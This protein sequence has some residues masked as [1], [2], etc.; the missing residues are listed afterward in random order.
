MSEQAERRRG[1]P[2]APEPGSAATTWLPQ[3]E[4]DQLIRVADQQ[5]ESVSA[6]IRQAIR[7]VLS[8]SHR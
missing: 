5:G 6:V 2:P 8:S 7:E 1:R 4:H 3:S